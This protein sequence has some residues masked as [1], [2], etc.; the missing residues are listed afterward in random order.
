MQVC[1][2]L[3]QSTGQPY[4]AVL[5]AA[6]TLRNKI[7]KQT[8]S[9]SADAL[10][11]LRDS[12]TSCINRH[13]AEMQ[14]ASVQLCIALSALVLQWTEWQDVLQHLGEARQLEAVAICAKTCSTAVSGVCVQD[15]G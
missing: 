5:Y 2:D 10:P 3:L 8:Q 11:G 9:L 12:L 13:S 7:R 14:A 15:R 4:P 1:S 6:Q